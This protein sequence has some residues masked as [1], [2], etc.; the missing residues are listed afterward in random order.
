MRVCTCGSMPLRII[1]VSV[2]SVFLFGCGSDGKSGPAQVNTNE[3]TGGLTAGGLTTGGLTTGGLTTGGETTGG[4]T[5]GGLTTGGDLTGGLTTGG[6]LTGGLTTGGLTTGGD[7]TGGLTTGGLTTGGNTTGGLTTGGLT[8]GG[9]TTGGLTDNSA[10]SCDGS[11]MWGP[12]VEDG[13]T[14]YM[15]EANGRSESIVPGCRLIRIYDAALN[16]SSAFTVDP[17]GIAEITAD[18]RLILRDQGVVEYDLPPA[19]ISVNALE[20]LSDCPEG[21]LGTTGGDNTGGDTTGGLTQLSCD[22][23]RVWGPTENGAELVY[24]SEAA[25][26]NTAHDC[27]LLI[28]YNPVQNCIVGVNYLADD[29]SATINQEGS[30]N[31]RSD[32]TELVLGVS[33]V[34]LTELTQIGECP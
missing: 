31:L 19:N 24:L 33:G 18:G 3:T 13:V 10:F 26:D 16:C 22:G 14:F 20:Q 2:L 28:R 9:L 27:A 34:S 30:V 17:D 6:D 12:A 32:N 11:R 7:L 1:C 4:L 5:S 8:T 25:G 29:A 23:I 21:I 15:S